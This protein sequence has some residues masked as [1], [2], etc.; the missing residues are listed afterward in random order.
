MLRIA[1]LD[2][3]PDQLALLGGFTQEYIET[4]KL[5]ADI[6]QFCHPDVLLTA[7]EIQTFHIYL[8]DM[9]MPM[10]SGLEVGRNIRLVSREAQII[11]ITSEPGYALD[12]YAV[13]PL[14]YLVKPIQ[15]EMLFSALGLA[16]S[17]VNFGNEAVITVK[18][19]AGLRTLAAGQIACCEYKN[20]TALYTLLGG[21]QVETTTLS[22][23]FTE[24]ISP[25]LRDERFLSPHISFAINMSRVEKLTRE[26]FMLREGS[27]IPVSAKQYAAVRDAYLDY[28]LSG[29]AK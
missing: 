11:Y 1:I 3:M 20:H 14:H 9:V 21:E 29:E 10:V 24:H 13:N 7:C 4:Q 18:T 26:G 25:L 23:S 28:R 19:R 8:L 27:F 6:Q 16:I 15:K 2:D 17:K 22:V 5:S 12:A